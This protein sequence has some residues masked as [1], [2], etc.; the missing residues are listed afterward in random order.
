MGRD[1][2]ARTCVDC[3]PEEYTDFVENTC[4]PCA[5]LIPSC[6]RCRFD[7]DGI[8]QC[9]ACADGL[10]WDVVDQAC[11]EHPASCTGETPI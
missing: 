9:H 2:E 11:V 5:D 10:V 1:L 4:L 8:L 7:G 3:L 6:S